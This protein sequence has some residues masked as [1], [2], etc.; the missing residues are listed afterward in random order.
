MNSR[1]HPMKTFLPAALALVLLSG[2]F[3]RAGGIL[4]EVWQNIG[5]TSVA[6]L[7]NNAAFPKSPT[8]TNVV[9]DFFEAPTDVLDQY[10]QRLH[11]YIVPPVTG[12]YT[13]WVSSDDGGQLWLSTDD[14][15]ANQ[16]LIA[17]VNGWTSPREWGKETNQKS[18]AIRLEQGRYYYVSAMMKEGGGGD[19]LAVRWL[20]P[21]N[22]DEGPISATNLQ[23]W[24]VTLAPPQIAQQPANTSAVEGQLARFQ[25]LLSSV[26]PAY[27][28]WRRNGVDLP[29]ANS[30]VLD[31]GPV[32][33]AD[34]NARFS[35]FITNKLGTATT[36]EARLSVLPDTTPPSLSSALNFGPTTIRLV[37]S[38]SIAPPGATTVANYQ[39]DNGVT[40]SGAVFGSDN[41]TVLLSTSPL[42]YGTTYTITVN[43]VTDL[44]SAPNAIP[45]GSR[46]RFL[47][48]E[49]APQ[50]IG[51]PTLGGGSKAVPGG[52]EVT[53]G[54]AGVGGTADQF[55]LSYRLLAGDFDYQA[56]VSDLTITDP[57][58]QAGLVLRESLDP[59]SR[60]AGIFASSAQLG[61]YFASRPTVGG[62]ASRAVPPTG[63]PVNYPQMWLRL[64]RAGTT[65]TGFAS[66]DGV[67]W[68]Q[69][70]STS[71]T[72]LPGTVY[73]GLAVSSQTDAA[74]CTAQFRD[75]GPAISTATGTYTPTA[76]PPGPSS[77]RTG[78]VIS[79][80]MYHP[81]DRPDGRNLEY[82]ELYNARSVFEDLSGWRLS[83]SVDYTFPAG[84]SLQAGEF[85]VI[86]A[87]PDDVKAVYGISNVLGPY[88]NN[89]PNDR[90]TIRLR[91]NA[92]AIRLEVNY[93]DSSSWP[94]A[95]DGAGHSLVLA[96]PSY[97][98]D[99]PQAWTAS[100]LRGGSP[101]QVDA[102]YPTSLREVVIN[103]VLA[104]TDPPSIDSLELYNHSNLPVDLSGCSLTDDPGT[105]KFALPAGTIIPARGFLAYD[106]T[107]LGFNLEAAGEALYLI[108]PGGTRVLD[109]VRF[110]GQGN[111]VAWGR[112]PDGS[113]RFRRL[114]SPTLGAANAPW[115][116]EDVVI[117]EI[118]YQPISG[119]NDDEYVEL[120]NRGGKSVDLSGWKFIHGIDFAFP[121]NTVLS[122]NSYLVVAKNKARLKA[123]HPQ[124]N[125]GNTVGDYSGSLANGGDRIS[126]ARP[127]D[128]IRTNE[129]GQVLTNWIWVTQTEAIYQT[130]GRWG[131]WADG[132]GSSLEL[133]DPRSDPLQPSNWA[134]SDESQKGRWTTNTFTG[135]LDNGNTGYLPD[136][137]F[138]LMLGPGECLVDDVEIYKAGG[139]NLIGNG[140]FESGAAGWSLQGNH[141]QS[142][143]ES[144]TAIS[145]S[146][147][148]RVR[149]QEDGDTGINSIRTPLAA[150]LANGNTVTLS[151]KARWVAG[152]PEVLF[153]VHGNY[154]EMPMRLPV[155]QNL[156]TPGL[157]N[158]RLVPNAGPAIY[159]VNHAPALPRANQP[160]TVTC[161]VSDPDSVGS[162]SLLYRVDPNTTLKTVVMNDNGAG[163]DAVAGDG[164][165][166]GIIPGQ[167]AGVIVA[168]RAQ[169]TDQ[170]AAPVTSLFPP[171]APAQECLVRWEDP[172]P[173]GNFPHHHLWSTRATE[174]ARG[175]TI[176]LNNTWRDATLVYGNSRVIYNVG[177]R[178]KGSPY[179]GG[180][181]DIVASTPGDDRLFGVRDRIYGSTGNGGSE[182]TGIRSQLA[183]WLGQ[184]LG[185]P[186]LNASY[187]LFYR[188]GGAFREI[189]EDLETPNQYY[190]DSWFPEGEEGELYK[191]AVWFEFDDNNSG[192]KAT[193]ATIQKFLSQGAYKLA[194]YRWT[195][196]THS[197][198]GTASN[199][200]N[201]LSLVTAANT[202]GASYVPGLLNQADL[203]QWMRV[204]SYNRLM[205]NWDAWS[206][207]VGQNMFIYKQPGLRWML[208]PW[209]IDFTFGAGDGPTAG[210][211][212]GQD[213]VMNTMYDNPTFRRMLWRSYLDAVNGPFLAKNYSPQI[214]A[215]RKVLL[216]NGIS[217]LQDP[218]GIKTWIEQRRGHIL[219]QITANDTP[220]FALT[221]NNGNNFNSPTGTVT[222]AGSAPF[223]VAS[224]EV[225]GVPY[226]PV[227]NGFTTFQIKFPLTQLTNR[228]TLVGKDA[229]G[230]PV[231]G[232]SDSI[233]ITYAGAIPQPRDYL[234]INEVHYNPA[235]PKASFIELWNRSSTTPFDLSGYRLEGVGYTFPTGAVIQANSY[236]LL[237]KDRASFATAYGLAPVFDEFP[238]SLDNGGERL[239]LV[240]PGA[241]PDGDVVISD[242]RYDNQ[243]PWPTDADGFGPSLQLVDAAQD[244]Y[245]VAN[246]AATA[247]NDVNRVTPGRANGVS[248]SLAPFPLLWINEVLPN[249]ASGAADNFGQREPYIELFN[250][251]AASLDLSSF[252]LT[253][254][255]TNLA[256][257]QFPP[258]ASIAPGQFLVVWADGDPGQSATGAW[259]TSF[260]L[261]PTN[262]MVALVRYQ[263]S[264]SAPAVMDYLSYNQISPDRAFGSFPDGEPRQRRL[265]YYA[266]PAAAN[267]A[268]FPELRVTINEFMAG[269]TN[270][271]ADPLDGKFKDWLEL[272]NA[273]TAAVDLGGYTLTDTLTNQTK[274]VIPPGY[275]VPP[276]GFLLVWADGKPGFNSIT[277]P[278]LHASFKLSK[279]NSQIGLFAPDGRMV[280]GFDYG[281]QTD[282]VSMGR[283]PNGGAPP[284]YAMSRPTPKAPN[285]LLGA[286]QPPGLGAI[287]DQTVTESKRLTF[288]AAATDPD[289]GD[290]LAFSLSP[291]APTGA[292]IHPDTGVFEWTP[293]EAQGPGAYRFAVQVTDSGTP[294]LTTV[295]RITVTVAEANQAPSLAS[296]ADQA[297]N[298]NSALTLTLS[299]SDPDAPGNA[300]TFSLPNGGPEGLSLDS[301][302][303]ALNWM[304]G[305]PQG[306]GTYAITVRVTDNG[307]PPLFDERTFTVTVN[308]INSAPVFDPVLPQTVQELALFAHTVRAV[309]PDDPAAQLIYSFDE[310]PAGALL[311]AKTGLIE[312]TPSEADGPT[313]AIFVV[314]ATEVNPPNQSGAV[315][316][317]VAV[318]EQNQPPTLEPLADFTVI[319]GR[320][321][322]FQARA[323]D[324]DLPAQ[325]LTFALEPGAPGEAAIDPATGVFS[326]TVDSDFGASTNRILV[327]VSDDGPGS[328]TATQAFSVVVVPQ[329]HAVISEIMT[330]PG[331]PGAEYI[332]LQNNS[333]RT[334]VDLSGIRLLGDNLAFDFPPATLLSP[335]QFLVVAADTAAFA[336]AYPGPVRVAGSYKGILGAAGDTL[337]LVRP[338]ATAEQDLVLN[339]VFFESAA[340][341]P[342]TAPG[343]AVS[344]QLLDPKRDNNRAGNWA[345]VPTNGLPTAPEWRFATATGVYKNANPLLYLY[346]Q[347]AG[348]VYVDDLQLV[349]GSTPGVG[350]NL[351]Q[352]GSFESPLTTG[353]TRTANTTR[354]D[355][356]SLV[357]HSGNASLRLVC[358]AGGT[359]QNSSLW[360]N[361]SGL[362]GDTTY[363]LSFWYLPVTNGATL[364]VRFSGNWIKT[365]T[366]LLFTPPPAATLHTP[367]FSNNVWAALPAFPSLRINEVVTRNVT[368][369]S[370]HAGEREPWIEL[371]NTGDAAVSLDGLFLSTNYGNLTNWAFPSGWSI[372][373]GSFLLVYADGEPGQTTGA[374]LH[375]GAQLPVTAGQHWS[376]AL[377]QLS[378]GRPVIIDYLNGSVGADDASFGRL[379]DGDPSSAHSSS[380][381]T[382]G[383]ANRSDPPPIILSVGLGPQG[384]P[385]FQWPAV[386]GQTYRVEYK[387]DIAQPDWTLL[388]T[389]TPTNGVCSFTDTAASGTP[390]R[391]YRVVGR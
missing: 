318:T 52:F 231:P 107:Q 19:N 147:C 171:N 320:T 164:L 27:Y 354:S 294:P 140:G 308:E 225:N 208:M 363:T 385:A 300:L 38:E 152:W 159:Q 129:L 104:H 17:W 295:E 41:R 71:I 250:S 21:D 168:F 155:P 64:K 217:N 144:G 33:M 265:F 234:V 91:N 84:F 252:Y 207:N 323:S 375:A 178:D 80:I 18:A 12:N 121:S 92:D 355:T 75:L 86:A 188:N 51:S 26:G 390:S 186:Y 287:G 150:G 35:A 277:N 2:T 219:G 213:P 249:N 74:T 236:L 243:L 293:S 1:F 177:F 73:L 78:M 259:H 264:P 270:T 241:T 106:A 366:D 146:Q 59:N 215:R 260:R 108:G 93:S 348:E 373:P 16:K 98:E 190:A 223:A 3:A 268:A 289:A 245:R 230:N 103:E 353:W 360:Q 328:L 55:Q 335:G 133:I 111:A 85:V 201:L 381:P 347:A 216:Q 197:A 299:A 29:G 361:V 165:Y 298:E 130:G 203:D 53:G 377:S 28:Q 255:P 157:P 384:Q 322:T 342:A 367:G 314:R 382:P 100:E 134:D 8:S 242:L 349:A 95:A 13:F 180:S 334:A 372:A 195:F 316:F 296:I 232:A 6:D 114:S 105:N 113:P 262:G 374:E 62:A 118:M 312:W 370:D 290:T 119:D 202:T 158:S 240:K 166:S 81:S 32:T 386:P 112:S 124:L 45:S 229:H 61:C 389:V 227:W 214:D 44:A 65:F 379:P 258:G 120:F 179:H 14:S 261:N 128:L 358:N 209:D 307:S 244:A 343:G 97:G 43:N 20:R 226:P 184:K 50:D 302:T 99:D 235:E 175:A 278:D 167:A 339:E 266:T 141:S 315:T 283:F 247:T 301:L 345:T 346:L 183:G 288:T 5:G 198:D 90:G 162:V 239:A 246:W 344:R 276:G 58:A 210:L 306:P 77:R 63:F 371:A 383:S 218:G 362:G 122:A 145:G 68:V 37:F 274:F 126:L 169:A 224:I 42:A 284:L 233:T 24:G 23:P 279:T 139:A 160:V 332:E 352:N 60:F 173:F 137:F 303:G 205:G 176:A 330:Q 376:L 340:P 9:A 143:V 311:N 11:G 102:V 49:Y 34:Q 127:E 116:V 238:S 206:Y 193:G 333:A 356:S 204:H 319:E 263:G 30:S 48:V 297:I 154:I 285:V 10:G 228:L 271:L 251:S 336:S 359:T 341:W 269:N 350:Q 40:I 237:V 212:G 275:V 221:L 357:R 273:G 391:F 39:C 253:D 282:G 281:P 256:R 57:F 47:A 7:T 351:I 329:W 254:N 82:I 187:L 132:G 267:N 327:R 305:E 200:T 380:Q 109:A 36:S 67:T 196:R 317:S 194:R 70:G 310:A 185:I 338:G 272:H 138:I 286:N 170:A 151:A 149:G 326:W 101:G 199:Y 331:K 191:V 153:R 88:T 309:D 83:G 125:D 96:R 156:G 324:A 46:I 292:V 280:D 368:G 89:L 378:E 94:T 66:F 172:I 211:W 56:R 22:V 110:E 31:F 115:R 304:P 79:E 117:N 174:T 325:N 321:V 313:N 136:R 365:D 182:A 257:W 220:A 364:T 4:R 192:F 388:T 15:P 123:N 387:T 248:Q 69:L 54:G 369:I 181:G 222:L 291:D 131:K 163:G 161:R 189:M 337:Q 142:A 135:T 87:S 148:L 25:V 76:E 72:G